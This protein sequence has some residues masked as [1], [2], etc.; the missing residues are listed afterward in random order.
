MSVKPPF[1]PP[2]SKDE[3]G[4][5]NWLYWL[6]AHEP[7][8]PAQEFEKRELERLVFGVSQWDEKLKKLGY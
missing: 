8:I 1:I 2:G 3:E 7:L 4:R 5:L 6:E